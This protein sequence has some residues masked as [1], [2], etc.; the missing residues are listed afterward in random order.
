MDALNTEIMATLDRKM[1]GKSLRKLSDLVSNV[2]MSDLDISLPKSD[3]ACSAPVSFVEVVAN[4][5][6]SITGQFFPFCF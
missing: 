1:D 5:R 2:K 3:S 6:Y 4:P